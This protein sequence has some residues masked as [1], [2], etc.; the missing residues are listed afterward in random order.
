[1]M[2]N[3]LSIIIVFGLLFSLNLNAQNY[4]ISQYNNQTVSTCSGNFYD[5]GGPSGGFS[6]NQ[7]YTITFCPSTPGA[8]IHL[9]FSQWNIS[10]GD[11]MEVFDGNSTA[12]ASFGVFNT[13]MSPVGMV[14]GASILNTTGC[15]TLRWTSVGAGQ[16][17]AATISCGLPCQTFYTS[18]VSSIPPFH[19]DSGIFYIDICPH[20]TITLV[21]GNTYPLNDSVYHQSDSTSLFVWDLGNGHIDTGITTQMVYDT[22]Q[23]YN[24]ELNSWDTNSCMASTFPKIR[25]R[26][27]TKPSFNGTH[28]L[29]YN[30]CQ[31]DTNTLIGV[32]QTKKWKANP[33]LGHAGTTFLPDGSGASYTSTLVFNSF[34]VGQVLTNPNN[35]V[36]VCA[37]MEHSYLGDMHITLTCPN[38]SM[39]TLKSYPGGGGTFL[40]EPIDDQSNLNPG[41]GYDYCWKNT[42]TITMNAAAGL[43]NHSFTDLAG[44]FYSNAS[45]LPPSTNYPAAS[46]ATLPYPTLNY[47]PITPFSS[48]VGCPLNGAWTITVTDNLLIDN[49]YI[50]SW[51]MEFAQSILPVSWSYQPVITSHAWNPNTNII[52]TNGSTVNII[53]PD[54]GNFTFVY[55]VVDNLGCAYDTSVAIYVSPRPTVDLGSDIVIC[56]QQAILLDATSNIPGVN[57]VWN[58]PFGPFTPSIT[59][60]TPGTWN[61]FWNVTVSSAN[62]SLQCSDSDTI[63]ITQYQPAVVN[64]GI[65]T[66]VLS[67]MTL[68]AENA[69][70][71]TTYYYN[72]SNGSTGQTLNVNTTGMYSVTVTPSTTIP[73]DVTDDIFV[74]VYEP[75]FLGT[76]LEFC[77]F[78]TKNIQAP[79][80]ITGHENSFVWAFDNT[81]SPN[82]TSQFLLESLQPGNHNLSVIIDG[83]C[84]DDIDIQINNCALTFTN[85]ITPNGDGKNDYFVIKGLEFFDNSIMKVYNRWGMRVY[86]STDYK[87]DWDGSDVSDGVYYFYLE[88]TEGRMEV[89]KG[90]ITVL[91][92]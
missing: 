89:Y 70:G 75:G 27:S 67:G 74:K 9:D 51:Q 30:V 85:I 5:S 29:T 3:L 41:V 2:K 47:S 25:V 56:G 16:G 19:V 62:G 36:A 46:T 13:G 23:G 54:T 35:I 15:L 22:V 58:A 55:T 53:S 39:A 11:A 32:V 45:Y 92:H 10:A 6:A 18:L 44:T 91:R 14:L 68:D 12:A 77:D 64:L 66:C 81:T 43:Y 73:C 87:N 49:G 72:W 71:Q 57:Y 50:F 69:G 88:L 59:I 24:I 90:T 61:G 83:T 26:V 52:G 17:W 80:G 63:K 78:E 4:N 60:N 82:I 28:P 20:D 79:T 37:N 42:G 76:D 34:A 48:L 84:V 31:G 38:G 65:D 7:I 1:M 8:Y 21:A 86:E 33:S 40:G